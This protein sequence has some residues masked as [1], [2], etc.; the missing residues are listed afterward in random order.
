MNVII[1]QVIVVQRSSIIEEFGNTYLVLPVR[2]FHK[3]GLLD[4]ASFTS[5]GK[6]VT[7]LICPYWRTQA[8]SMNES[9]KIMQRYANEVSRSLDQLGLVVKSEGDVKILSAPDL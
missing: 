2:V 6:Y 7:I 3:L 9:S 1:N 4:L 8:E 5:N